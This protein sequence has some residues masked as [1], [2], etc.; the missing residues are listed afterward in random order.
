MNSHDHPEEFAA[1]SEYLIVCVDCGQMFD[2]DDDDARCPASSGTAYHR[3]AVA[4][5][6]GM[7]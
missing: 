6:E 4:A 2:P 7:D 3:G 5:S 1:A